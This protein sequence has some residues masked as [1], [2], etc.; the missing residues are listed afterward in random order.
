[1]NMDVRWKGLWATEDAAR[2]TAS[3]AD[4][5]QLVRR[6]L[7]TRKQMVSTVN[8]W[9]L[10]RGSTEDKLDA[11]LLIAVRD[12][13]TADKLLLGAITAHA[14]GNHTQ[15]YLD[16]LSAD[17]VANLGSHAYYYGFWTA[18]DRALRGLHLPLIP[19]RDGLV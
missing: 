12:R 1:M 18:L 7:R 9:P 6:D 13:I 15:F 5:Q 16:T 4:A 11:L 19:A 8:G 14:A 3:M 17:R 2:S 10:H